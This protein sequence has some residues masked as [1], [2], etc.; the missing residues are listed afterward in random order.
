MPIQQGPNTS[1]LSFYWDLPPITRTLITAFVGLRAVQ[2][3]DILPVPY[4]TYLSWSNI[5]FRWQVTHIL[6]PVPTVQIAT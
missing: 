4:L 3:L 1:P 5:V 2:A 6:A